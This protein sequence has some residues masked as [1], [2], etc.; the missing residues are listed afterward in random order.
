MIS[1]KEIT[2]KREEICNI[3]IKK[4]VLSFVTVGRLE[5][6]KRIDRL[7]NICKRLKKILFG[8]S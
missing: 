5:K 7:L 1:V 8:I 2:E 6:E 3:K 4:E